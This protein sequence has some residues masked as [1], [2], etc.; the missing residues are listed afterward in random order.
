MIPRRAA[1]LA[2][3]LFQTLKTLIAHLSSNKVP[4]TYDQRQW[5]CEKQ[6]LE[7]AFTEALRVKA[8]TLVSDHVFEVVLPTS[9]MLLDLKSMDVEKVTKSRESTGKRLIKFTLAPGLRSCE[10]DRPLVDYHSFR[11]AGSQSEF[12]FDEL[13]K[14]LVLE[15]IGNSSAMLS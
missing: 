14:P 7:T 15:H 1:L 10:Y 4:T 6:H 12:H 8:S 2:D 5:N 3:R 13:V 11:K 9:G